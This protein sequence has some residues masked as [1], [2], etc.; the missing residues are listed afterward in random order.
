M[1]AT[2]ECPTCGADARLVYC[3][4]CRACGDAD[5]VATINEVLPEEDGDG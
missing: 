1:T 3:G 5:V 4:Q 2:I